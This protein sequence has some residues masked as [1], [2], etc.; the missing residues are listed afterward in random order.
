MGVLGKVNEESQ[1]I[2]PSSIGF[3]FRFLEEQQINGLVDEW[4]V[5]ISFY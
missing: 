5:H 4:K 3:L 2:I 1:G